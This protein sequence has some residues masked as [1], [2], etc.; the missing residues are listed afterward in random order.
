M[1][2]GMIKKKIKQAAI[3]LLQE[4]LGV[5]KSAD[6]NVTIN[7]DGKIEVNIKFNKKF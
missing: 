4:T 7:P 1:L 6:C 3:E 5:L 2:K